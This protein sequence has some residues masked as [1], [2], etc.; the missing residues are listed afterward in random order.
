MRRRD[1]IKVIGGA[2]TAWPFSTQA[3]QT[4][5][6]RR[7]G[8][9]IGLAP[10]DSEGQRWLNTFVQTLRELGWR[11]GTNVQIDLRWAGTIDQMRTATKELVD[12]KPDLIH[13]TTAVAT[14]EILRQ[15][16]TIPV[17]FSVVND[18]V[19]S[20]F[21]Q[22]LE[23]PTGNA[24]GFTNIVPE[25]GKK[26]LELLKEI[27]PRVTRAAM[28][29]NPVPGSQVEVRLA[30][31]AA[32]A[33]SLGMTAELIPVRDIAEIEK[34]IEALGDDSQAGFVV[35]P[36]AF[37]NLSRSGLI[38]S[39]ASRHRVAAV[40]PARDFVFARGLASYS[41]DVPE[42]QRRSARYADRILKG[43]TISNLPVEAPNKFALVINLRSAKEI[44]L[45]VPPAL[46]GRATEIIE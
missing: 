14:S 11:T 7:V 1:F 4:G 31:L 22:N 30:Q 24:T 9:L 8:V 23:R 26:W 25:M 38:T 37:F 5:P 18:P 21:T 32:T 6:M 19:A 44:G 43:E 45:T 46:L 17:V 34:S 28:L 15:T 33:P 36:D 42:L 2:A 3:Q 41:V 39:L 35:I 40:Y 12:L 13:V 29:F 16:A 10:G 20:G 27:A